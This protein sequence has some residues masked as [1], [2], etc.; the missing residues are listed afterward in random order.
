MKE[1]KQKK[2]KKTEAEKNRETI[3]KIN[4]GRELPSEAELA[5]KFQKLL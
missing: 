3:R 4:P 1:N 2:R 5:R